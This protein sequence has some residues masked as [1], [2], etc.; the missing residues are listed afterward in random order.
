M[1]IDLT[2]MSKLGFGLMR[3]PEKDGSIDIERVKTMVDRYMSAGM[4]YFDTAY[5]YHGG[6]SEGAA[7]EAIVKRYP[8]E[9][10]MLATKL[11]AWE[12]KKE[13]DIERIFNE[14]C[15]RAGVDYF[16][17]YLLHSIEDGS[18]YDT[19]EKY[20][21]FSWGLKKKAEGKIKH[22]GFSYHGTP[23]LLETILDKHPEM[24]FVQIQLNYLDRTNPV[25]QSQK[26]YDILHKR[27]IPMIIMEPVRGGMLAN[28]LPEIEAKFKALRPNNS[29]ASWALRYVGSLEGIITILSGMSDEAQMEDN[30]KTFT[31]FEP[32]TAEEMKLIDEVTDDILR[33]PQIGCTA[34]KYCI[35]GCPMKIS[36]PDIFRTINT[37]RRYPDDWRAKNFYSGLITRSG[38]ASD[39]VSCGQCEGVCP[40][41]LPII[42]LL[43][44]AAGILDS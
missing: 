32:L 11:P 14:Q 21:C 33:I 18:N 20:D 2:K 40:Q 13:S 31:D 24:E 4:N 22:F 7:K 25:V 39:C 16:D 37:L 6:K 15:Q 44:E 28:M 35:D 30:I 10:F 9:K 38:K 3:L 27:N 43:K 41:H 19:Y 5:V 36:I 17:F 12:I 26:L 8:R 23:E 42:D 1:G 29:I 34:C